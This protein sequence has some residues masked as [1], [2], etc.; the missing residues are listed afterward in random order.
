MN[1]KLI[2]WLVAAVIAVVAA[3]ALT[4][5]VPAVK[6]SISAQELAELQGS[7]A[8]VIDVRTN[9]EFITGHLPNSLSAGLHGV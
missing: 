1:R 6:K 5:P 8:W 7:G 4:T 2:V 9:S 3:A